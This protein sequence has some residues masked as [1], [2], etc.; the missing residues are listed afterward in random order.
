MENTVSFLRYFIHFMLKCGRIIF[1][2]ERKNSNSSCLGHRRFAS[3]EYAPIQLCRFALTGH[4]WF[5]DITVFRHS[6][7]YSC[8]F[9]INGWIQRSHIKKEKNHLHEEVVSLAL[10]LFS[11]NFC[12]RIWANSNGTTQQR[13]KRHGHIQNDQ[14]SLCISMA[15][16]Q[17][18]NDIAE[19]YA[20]RS[21]QFDDMEFGFVDSVCDNEMKWDE[22]IIP[23][24]SHHRRA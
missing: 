10:S 5:N 22:T 23:R 21:D 13:T 6:K 24:R 3:I 15:R 19:I 1:T 9:F 14:W 17:H 4:S 7:E 12:Y 8:V 20:P 2:D 18:K 16:R 11:F